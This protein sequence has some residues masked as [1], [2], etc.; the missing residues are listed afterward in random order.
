[1]KKNFFK[2]TIIQ[3]VLLLILLGCGLTLLSLTVSVEPLNTLVIFIIVTG[4]GLWACHKTCIVVVDPKLKVLGTLWL[5]KIIITLFLLY[6]GWIPQLDPSSTSWG[7]DPQRYFQDAWIL[8]EDG[9]NPSVGSNYQG[10]IFF[11]AAIFYLFGHNPVIPALIN[12]FITLLGTLFLIRGCYSF[13]PE[14]SGK[15]WTIAGLLLVP[16]VLWYDVITSR[17]TMMAVLIIISTFSV[18]RYLVRVKNVKLATT[19]LLSGS[20]L[21]A[22]LAVR[23]SLAIPVVAS[24]GVM[25]MLLRSERKTGPFVK[26]LLILLAIAGLAAGALV[27][28]LTGGYDINYQQT[29]NSIQSFEGNIASYNDWSDNSIGLL[30][31]PNNAWQSVIYLPMR[32]VLYL[33]APLPNVAVSLTELISGSWVAWQNLMTIPTSVMMLLGLPFALAGA[34]QAWRFRRN[35]PAPLV[36]HISFWITFMAV[37]GGNIIIHERYRVMFTLLLFACMWFGYTRCPRHELKRWA[38]PWFGLLASAA[39]F[40]V[41]YKFIG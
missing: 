17:E 36:L 16:E 29:F 13:V 4:L 19:V 34:A 1:L 9:W 2:I 12:A 18:G 35:Q 33:A 28:Q 5:I 6:V 24:I 25:V 14:R 7:Y 41:G 40:Y 11:Y 22:I 8:I 15:E 26:I 38:L 27:Q 32:M 39:V 10:I 20:A 30:I 23:T 31:A 37:A 21:I 3:T